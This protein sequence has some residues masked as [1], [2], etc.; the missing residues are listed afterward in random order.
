MRR[1]VAIALSSALVLQAAPLVA[2]TAARAGAQAPVATG[3][4]NGTAQ[5]SSGQLLQNYTVQ[6]RNLQTGQ[7]AATTNSN[8]AGS[9]SFAGLNPG[10]YIIEV[11]NQSGAIVGSSSS[12]AVT[13][14]ATV[15]VAVS[16]TAL[17]AAGAAAG[18]AGA[19]AAIGGISTA[20]VV[21]TVAVAAGIA[22]VVVATR[23]NA[24]PS[25]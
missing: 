13:S 2:A 12:I 14:G 11:V 10:N 21:T 20:L 3:A 7:L 25:R 17:A 4:V 19:G 24:S 1:F 5:S 16:T 9:F 23:P 8:A 22:G 15:T 18:A 6:L